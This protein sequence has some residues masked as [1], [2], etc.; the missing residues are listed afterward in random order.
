M[1]HFQVLP[2]AGLRSLKSADQLDVSSARG[3]AASGS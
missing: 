2:F 3:K 1:F